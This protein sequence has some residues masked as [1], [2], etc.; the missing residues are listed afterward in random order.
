MTLTEQFRGV[1][2]LLKIKIAELVKLPKG[3]LLCSQEPAMCIS[4]LHPCIIPS[5]LITPL[6]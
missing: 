1:H 4:H 6:I 3:L 5:S 2:L